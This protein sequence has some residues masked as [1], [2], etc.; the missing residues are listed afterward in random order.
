M[1]TQEL[2]EAP[3]LLVEYVR[4]LNDQPLVLTLNGQPLCLLLP[5]EGSDLET[6][7]LSMNPKFLAIIERSRIR[8]AVEG[9]ISSEEMRERLGLKPKVDGKEKARARKPKAKR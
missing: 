2:A 5:V 7:S 9:G 8:Q 3:T 4:G 1:K 6:V